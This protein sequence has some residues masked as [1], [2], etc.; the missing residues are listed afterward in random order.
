MSAAFDGCGAS[1][2]PGGGSACAE[3]YI[4][5]EF[6][7]GAEAFGSRDQVFCLWRSEYAALFLQTSAA[8]LMFLG[9]LH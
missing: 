3:F 9:L 6:D 7:N 1:D 2:H 4:K 5:F 8:L